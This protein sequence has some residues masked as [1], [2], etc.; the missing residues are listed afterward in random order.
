[1]ALQASVAVRNAMVD[2]FASTVGAS[3]EIYLWSTGSYPA[4]CAAA[5]TGTAFVAIIL[6]TTWL[7]AASAGTASKAGT[8]SA[9]AVNTGDPVLFRLY[10]S[11]PGTCHLQG[12]VGIGS[13]DMPVSGTITSGQA[14]TINT[15]TL[16]AGNV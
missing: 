10:A 14:V 7:N 11:G 15:F 12:T 4:N 9:T 13:G 3:A 1:M 2:A 5:V 6:P 16:T 8:W